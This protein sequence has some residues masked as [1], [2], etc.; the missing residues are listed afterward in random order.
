MLAS[1]T[2]GVRQPKW[3]PASMLLGGNSEHAPCSKQIVN[4][5]GI[6]GL[7]PLSVERSLISHRATSGSRL[8]KAA[9]RAVPLAG[10]FARAVRPDDRNVITRIHG[11][12]EVVDDTAIVK[13][14]T[15]R[16]H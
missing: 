13:L 6:G 3:L 15:Q 10:R 4:A 2:S 9:N 8:G 16:L 7:L 14:N 5:I 11:E 12:T 1:K